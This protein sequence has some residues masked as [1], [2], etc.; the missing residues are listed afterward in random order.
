[1]SDDKSKIVETVEQ[2]TQEG[3]VQDAVDTQNIPEEFN[4]L[5]F[6]SDT[7]IEVNKEKKEE[8]E[9]EVINN[10]EESKTEVQ[11]EVK[12][13]DG[14]FKWDDIETESK[15]EVKE[16]EDDDWDAGDDEVTVSETSEDVPVQ[17]E[18]LDWKKMQELG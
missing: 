14:S 8:N 11:E 2:E 17:E 9:K 12:E 3:S 7:P 13:D 1:M 16:E 18:K 6:T 5:A 4:P 15:E 10:S